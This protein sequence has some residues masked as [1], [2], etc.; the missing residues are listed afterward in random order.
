[1]KNKTIGHIPQR[2]RLAALLKSGRVPQAF[3]FSGIPGIG[4][5]RLATGF[6]SALF[7]ESEKKPCG[8]CTSCRQIEQGIHPDF[9]TLE[10]D[11]KGTIPI[12]DADKREHG[13]VRWLISRLANKAISGRYGVIIDGFEN[14]SMAAQNALLK[15]IEEPSGGTCIIMIASSSGG[16]L[17]TIMS[18]SMLV[19]FNPLS[20]REILSILGTE[21]GGAEAEFAAVASGGSVVYAKMLMDEEYRALVIKLCDAMSASARYGAPFDIDE[22]RMPAGKK[23]LDVINF[24]INIYEYNLRVLLA[25]SAEY[26]GYMENLYIDEVPALHKIIKSLM[27]I[28]SSLH[29]NINPEFALKGASYSIFEG[30]YDAPGLDR[31]NIY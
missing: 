11:E 13:S 10:P 4:K 7:C 1:M 14:V 20:S 3:I 24:M 21:D 16:I 25:K 5:R 26:S 29:R 23:S 28:K 8:D 12:G 17:D 31:L 2:Q 15:T 30:T 18:R 22:S 9:I 27:I 19:K 6:L